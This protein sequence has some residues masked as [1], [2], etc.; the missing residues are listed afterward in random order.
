MCQIEKAMEPGSES[1][2]W[3]S[4]LTFVNAVFCLDGRGCGLCKG[5]QLLAS[6]LYV[7][8]TVFA[9]PGF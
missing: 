1:G 8:Y 2:L 3:T 4:D 6:D 7:G 5:S 9:S